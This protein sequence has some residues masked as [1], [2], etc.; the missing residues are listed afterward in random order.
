ML[1]DLIPWLLQYHKHQGYLHV[2]LIWSAP[3]KMVVQLIGCKSTGSTQNVHVLGSLIVS[4]DRTAF[5]V[6]TRGI[7]S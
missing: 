3:S 6:E 5:K 4:K 2:E 7:L 1:W